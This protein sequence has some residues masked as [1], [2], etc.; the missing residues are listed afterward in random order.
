MSQ[1]GG[2]QTSKKVPP[3]IVVAVRRLPGLAYELTLTGN[4]Q[5]VAFLSAERWP[6]SH[7]IYCSP[8][9]LSWKKRYVSA[10]PSDFLQPVT[11]SPEPCRISVEVVV[12]S[13]DVPSDVLSVAGGSAFPK[14]PDFSD[15]FA[16]EESAALLPNTPPKTAPRITRTAITAPMITHNRFFPDPAAVENGCGGGNG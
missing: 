8:S 14:L 3:I 4:V 16:D 2:K 15:R 1:R 7:R 5:H 12:L 10:L 9:F 6:L 11:A 13:G